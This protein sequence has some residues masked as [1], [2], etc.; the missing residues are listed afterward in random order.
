M[1]IYFGILLVSR[2]TFYVQFSP[3]HC[4]L[5]S[6]ITSH[7]QV[8][9]AWPVLIRAKLRYKTPCR[10]LQNCNILTDDAHPKIKERTL[11]HTGRKDA[12]LKENRYE[13]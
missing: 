11:D 8:Y 2:V 3:S 10:V 5:K 9:L 1:S 7:H 13:Y 4:N 12:H 6:Y